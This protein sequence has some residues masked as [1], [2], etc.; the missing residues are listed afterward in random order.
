MLRTICVLLIT[1]IGSALSFAQSELSDYRAEIRAVRH[2]AID[3]KSEG[4]ISF[5]HTDQN[6]WQL[7]VRLNDGPLKLSETTHGEITDD[8]LYRPL[9]F[10]RRLKILFYRE[11]INWR[12]D[13]A[14][15][16]VSGQVKKDSHSHP[17]RELIHD[18]NSFQI[19]MRQGLKA[20]ETEFNFR[21]MRYSR[22]DDLAFEVVG[23]ELLTLAG[24]RVHTL[25]IRQTDP[26]RRDE[27][28]LIWVAKD[29]NFIPVRFST[30]DDGKL[31]DELV[32]EKLWVDGKEVRFNP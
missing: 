7:K 19:P 10:E 24:G 3:I 8:G 25:I 22:P 14:K 5:N 30:Y 15:Q 9:D 4:Y 23:E 21:F 31:K 32:V 6:S 1:L 28:K 17:L 20:G 2:G 11:D 29:H 27:K 12:F 16:T 26:L 13:W 18:P